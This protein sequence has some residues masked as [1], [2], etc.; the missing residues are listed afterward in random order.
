MSQAI[1]A[2]SD[3]TLMHQTAR[4][5]KGTS[6]GDVWSLLLEGLGFFGITAVRYGLTR[7]RYGMSLGDL[8]DIL[9]LSSL[10]AQDFTDYI[11]TGLYRR[12]PHYRWMAENDGVVSWGWFVDQ[13]QAGNLLEDEQLF[14]QE[15]EAVG[16]PAGYLLSF[17]SDTT[18]LKGGLGMMGQRDWSQAQMDELWL[19]HGE[20]IEAMCI[21]AHLNITR[22]PLPSKRNP[23]RP[24][25]REMLEWIAEGKSIQDVA[26]LTSLSVATVE[27]H[28]RGARDA[29]DVDTTAQ[30][31]ARAALLGQLFVVGQDSTA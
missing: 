7:S 25:Q 16:Q 21:A 31:I 23:L 26:V 11:E 1:H 28:L 3:A 10:G 24:R 9:F 17:P 27:K 8:Q 19:H 20:A 4:I 2:P 30:A 29:L 6:Y 15:M 14:L 18:R 22:M 5:L 12:S 13:A